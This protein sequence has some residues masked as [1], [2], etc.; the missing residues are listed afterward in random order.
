MVLS[1]FITV[2]RAASV[3]ATPNES[4]LFLE[5]CVHPVAL[6]VFYKERGRCQWIRGGFKG[7]K[8][9]RDKAGGKKDKTCTILEKPV[10]VE[11]T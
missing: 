9:R 5:Q 8:L 3:R 4:G 1:A 7:N 10:T 6:S 2:G 11:M